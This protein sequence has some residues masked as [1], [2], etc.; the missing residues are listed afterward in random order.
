VLPDLVHWAWQRWEV[1]VMHRELKCGFGLGDQQQW[2]PTSAALVPQWVV[3]TYAMLVLAA[4]ETWGTGPPPAAS[5]WHRG[6]R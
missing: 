1:E 3:W 6:R 5:R 4:Q 2:H